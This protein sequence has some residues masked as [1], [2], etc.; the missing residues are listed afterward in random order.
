[1]TMSNRK[2]SDGLFENEDTACRRAWIEKA[3]AT[4]RKL[5]ETS[6]E[7]TEAPEESTG[8]NLYVVNS[9]NSG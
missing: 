7:I 1:M 5:M 9:N 2:H 3:L 4:V 6:E 8:P